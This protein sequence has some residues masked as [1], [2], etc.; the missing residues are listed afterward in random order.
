MSS[1]PK[2]RVAVDIFSLRRKDPHAMC[3]LLLADEVVTAMPLARGM[4][5][6]ERI[7]E[8]DEFPLTKKFLNE[9]LWLLKLAGTSPPVVRCNVGSDHTMDA[10]DW[11]ARFMRNHEVLST[12]I[13]RAEKENRDVFSS[14]EQSQEFYS[15]GILTEGPTVANLVSFLTLNTALDLFALKHS[16]PVLTDL[17][18]QAVFQQ[19]QAQAQAMPMRSP[20]LAAGSELFRYLVPILRRAPWEELV[21]AREILGDTLHPLRLALSRVAAMHHQG[22]DPSDLR[23][24]VES[25]LLPHLEEY[26]RAFRSRGARLLSATR[27]VEH[28]VLT[29]TVA[30]VGLLV[31]G[32]PLPAAAAAGLAVAGGTIAATY[33]RDAGI[34]RELERK[35]MFGFLAGLERK[36][37][38]GSLEAVASTAQG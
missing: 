13:H 15:S 8:G 23:A 27:N 10:I 34:Q 33:L 29:G 16:I 26:R 18:P 7:V 4:E 14:F 28:E 1:D 19:L 35:H 30:L 22:S 11:T 2:L 20:F 5:H 31:A 6:C 32:T 25:E 3:A 17:Q 37:P 38:K 36:S 21:R 9:M 12:F 24:T